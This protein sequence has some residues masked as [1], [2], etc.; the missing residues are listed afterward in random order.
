TAPQRATLSVRSRHQ[1]RVGDPLGPRSA[2]RGGSSALEPDPQVMC[3]GRGERRDLLR[4]EGR[5]R[6]S[7]EVADRADL[8]PAQVHVLEP[9]MGEGEAAHPAVPEGDTGGGGTGEIELLDG[10]VL[11]EDVL[12]GSRAQVD[13]VELAGG[14]TEG[15]ELGVADVQRPEPGAAELHVPPG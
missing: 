11:D 6:E 1:A 14:D 8:Q 5:S 4:I 9:G 12:E 10:A 3:E 15:A 13:P 7:L 2:A